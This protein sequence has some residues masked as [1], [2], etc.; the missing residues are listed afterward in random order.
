VGET[1]AEGAAGADLRVG[2]V[3]QGA[4]EQ[5]RAHGHQRLALQ[6]ALASERSDG[7]RP[8]LVGAHEVELA[9][10]VE[11]DQQGGLGEPEI[12]HRDQALAAGQQLGLRAMGAHHRHRLG[13]GRGSEIGK[14]RGFHRRFRD[15][16]GAWSRRDSI[17]PVVR[18]VSCLSQ[19]ASDFRSWPGAP[20]NEY[21]CRI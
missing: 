14:R 11:V 17:P 19:V 6:P 8:V 15:R 1:A 21:P 3:G 4:G 13:E 2:D 20:T 5:R 18:P 10:A 16:L 12:H 7:E 9:E